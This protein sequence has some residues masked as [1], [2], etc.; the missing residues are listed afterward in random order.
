MLRAGPPPRPTP[1]H[2]ARAT[3]STKPPVRG[4]CGKSGLASS[5]GPAPSAAS[6]A[7][8]PNH[9]TRQRHR[10]HPPGCRRPLSHHQQRRPHPCPTIRTRHRS[11]Q[12]RRL[13][14]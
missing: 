10:H 13:R 14:S 4:R 9:S 7:A 11:D 12:V 6:T 8:K 1:H 2:C 5:N 3:I